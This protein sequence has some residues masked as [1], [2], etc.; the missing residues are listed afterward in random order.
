MTS[1]NRREFFARS[2]I[3][4]L[5]LAAG[6]MIAAN[7]DTNDETD[8]HTRRLPAARAVVQMDKRNSAA[9]VWNQVEMRVQ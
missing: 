5:S 7:F 6:G 2:R 9:G 8:H 4:G 1:L 3:A